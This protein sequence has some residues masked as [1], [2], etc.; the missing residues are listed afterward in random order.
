MRTTDLGAGQPEFRPQL[1]PLPA[2]GQARPGQA[3]LNLS[4]PQLSSH[5]NED[6]NSTCASRGG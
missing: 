3:T 1:L 2:H 4:G 5:W 6:N